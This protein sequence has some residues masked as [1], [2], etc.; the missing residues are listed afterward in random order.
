MRSCSQGT[1][2]KF[3]HL[4]STCVMLTE[5]LLTRV[6]VTRGFISCFLFGTSEEVIHEWPIPPSEC[7]QQPGRVSAIESGL[8]SLESICRTCVMVGLCQDT[9]WMHSSAT[10]MKHETSSSGYSTSSGSTMSNRLLSSFS[11]HVCIISTP[12]HQAL[13]HHILLKNNI[14][15]YSWRVNSAIPIV[16]GYE[17]IYLMS[18]IHSIE[19]NQFG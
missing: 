4:G 12:T 19:S 7:L 8:T 11:F 15:M 1:S 17:I 3:F 2:L 9:A 13:R 6:E 5:Q 14:N 18:L 16:I 10:L